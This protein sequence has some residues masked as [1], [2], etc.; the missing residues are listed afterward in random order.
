MNL[1]GTSSSG[2]QP[3]RSGIHRFFKNT[4]HQSTDPFGFFNPFAQNSNNTEETVNAQPA[5]TAAISQAQTDSNNID[6]I[7]KKYKQMSLN[8][9]YQPKTPQPSQNTQP[10]INEGILIG[11]V[12]FF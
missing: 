12:C 5:A 11:E 4:K 1:G 2:T 7:L 3:K 6:N 10:A 8:T 9:E